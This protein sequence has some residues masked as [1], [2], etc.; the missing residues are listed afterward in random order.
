MNENFAVE[1]SPIFPMKKFSFLFSCVSV[2]I[3]SACSP[4]VPPP[5][6]VKLGYIGPLT[7]DAVSYGSDTL[8]AV[9]LAVDA[10]NAS[11]G[12]M[13]KHIV[14]IAEDG[15]CNGADSANAAQK[16]VNVDKVIAIV[17]GQCSSETLAAAPIAESAK[18][19]LLSPFSSHPDITAAGQYVFRNYPSDALKGTA[20]NNYFQSAGFKKIAVIS[21]NTD[22]CQGVLSSMVGGVLSGTTVVFNETVD[23]GTKDFRS[24]LTRLKDMEFDLFIPNGQS[25]ATILEMVKQ[26]REL[27]MNQQIVGTDAADSLTLAQGA[28]EAVEGM[29]VLS[30][31]AL[32]DAN[33]LAASFKTAFETKAGPAKQTLFAAG[34]AF[35][36]TNLLLN[37]IALSGSGDTLRAALATMTPYTG[38]A[39]TFSFDPNGDV[40]GIPYAL[41]EFKGGQLMQSALIPLQ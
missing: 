25:D 19:V 38:A 10:R 5:E 16:L 29:K 41:K 7:G 24:L 40:L 26:L 13:G 9:S 35:D 8:N 1:F 14:L 20:L 4:A 27:G 15:K 39:G 22:F 28:P 17:G 3:L 30:V 21:E 6:V 12:I 32:D 36:A 31:P 18:V 34:L 37:T 11:G 2:L 33:P 23:A